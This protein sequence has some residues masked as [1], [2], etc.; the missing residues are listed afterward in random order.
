LDPKVGAFVPNPL[1]LNEGTLGVVVDPPNSEEEVEEVEVEPKGVVGVV[2]EEVDPPNGVVEVVPNGGFE[3]VEDVPKAGV[4]EVVN[5]VEAAFP[6]KLNPLEEVV[7]PGALVPNKDELV[8]GVDDEFPN[9]LEPPKS[10]FFSSVATEGVF[11]PVK[12]NPEEEEVFVELSNG[13]TFI[14]D[15][16]S[17]LGSEEI[18]PPKSDFESV[19]EGDSQGTIYRID[20]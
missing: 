19:I 16:S 14:L 12:L 5:G 15:D 6:V 13:I 10:D 2:V 1:P 8:E 18:D 11:V 7:V 4:V 20:Y 3:D 9:K 17:F